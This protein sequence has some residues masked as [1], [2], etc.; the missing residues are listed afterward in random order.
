MRWWIGGLVAL[1]ALISAQGALACSGS[2]REKLIEFKFQDEA[3][4]ALYIEPATVPCGE[5]RPLVIAL[6]GGGGSI[7]SMAEHYNFRREAEKHGW[8]LLVPNGISRF[9]SGKFA[10]WNAGT[11]CGR[12]QETGADDVAFIRA[13]LAQARKLGFRFD[14]ARIYASGMSNGAMMSYQLACNGEGLVRG[15]A[16]VAG[17]DNTLSCNPPRPVAVLHIHATDDRNVL[18]NGGCGPDCVTGTNFTSVPATMAKWRRINR[19]GNKAVHVDAKPGYKCTTWRGSAD[20]VT[21]CEM[22]GGGHSWPGG[23]KFYRRQAEPSQ[24]MDATARIYAFFKAN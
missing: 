20:P 1:S 6:H 9:R 15:I 10:T 18:F 3:R 8:P 14:E 11:C 21:L 19:T 4:R 13:V 5:D 24:A 16:P 12:A 7:D 2:A 22:Q 17:T 23:E